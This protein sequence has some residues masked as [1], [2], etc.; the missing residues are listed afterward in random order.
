MAGNVWEWTSSLYKPYPY[1]ATDG[2]EDMASSGNRVLRGGSWFNL[3]DYVRSAY[4]AND[5]PDGID[6]SVGFRCARSP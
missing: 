4:R 2:R 5:A 3:D 6:N 1:D